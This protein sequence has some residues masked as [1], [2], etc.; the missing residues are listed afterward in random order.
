MKT[1]EDF[2]HALESGNVL[3]TRE[4]TFNEYADQIARFEDNVCK[5]V[6]GDRYHEKMRIDEATFLMD[7]LARSKGLRSDPAVHN[8]LLTMKKL[9]KEIAIL[10]SGANGERLVSRTL[11][12][13]DR[14]DT[15]IYRNIYVT[16]GRDETELDDVV[17]TDSGVIILEVKKVKTDITLTE[18]G[19]MV[20]AGDE[21][22]DKIPLGERMALKRRLLKKHLEKTL[23]DKELD[24]PVHVD[25][26]IVFSAPKGQFIRVNDKCH[27]EKYCFRTCLNKKIE[28]Y[29]GCAY[30]KAD[31]MAQL[32][33]ILSEMAADVKRFETGADFNDV[34]RSLAEAM[35]VLQREPAGEQTSSTIGN[36]AK[37]IGINAVRNKLSC[38]QEGSRAIGLRGK[39]SM[40]LAKVLLSGAEAALSMG[41]QN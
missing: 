14:P 29:L 38:G 33:A 41:G 23:A 15:K 28:G 17:L 3:M 8:G 2:I 37:V 13:L 40:A 1:A 36:K 39:L 16:D 20:Y 34:R 27:R 25:S 9:A 22:Y 24:I 32:N 30:Y 4:L 21:C 18:D 6:A 7:S 5:M 31:Q 10:M 11:E 35:V 19:R 26:F 12:F